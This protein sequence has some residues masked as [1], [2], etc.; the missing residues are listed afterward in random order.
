MRA[1]LG[2]LAPRIR[3]RLPMVSSL[4]LWAGAG[5]VLAQESVTVQA[6]WSAE[7][8]QSSR[9]ELELMLSRTLQTPV[10]R[11]ALLV[12]TLDVSAFVD[13]KGQRARYRPAAAR[14][15]AGESEVIAYVVTAAGDWQ[16]I[17]RF[18]L[19]VRNRV[20]VDRSGVVPVVDL[21]STGQLDQRVADGEPPPARKTYQDLTL[22]MGFEGQVARQGWQIT[23]QANALGVTEKA[24]RLRWSEMQ[25]D[26]PAVDLSDYRIRVAEGRSHLTLGT[27]TAGNHRYLLNNF[28]SRGIATALEAGSFAILDAAV[29]NGTNVVGWSNPFGLMRP[30]HQILSATLSLELLP[31]RPG[32]IHVGISGL[33]GSVLPLTSINQGSVTDAEKNRAMGVA[34][35]LSDA[36]QRFRFS[37]GFARSRYANPADPLLAGD[38]ILVPVQ[39]TVRSARHAELAVQ[40]LRGWALTQSMQTT[41]GATVRHERVDPLYR[42][43]GS[44]GQ[45]DVENNGLELQAT[46]GALA[47]QATASEARDNL[48]HIAS[49][50]TTRTRNRGVTGTLP[51]GTLLR[52]QNAWYWPALNASWQRVRQFG[53]GLPT[54]GDFSA[55]HVPD[56]LNTTES[57]SLGWNRGSASLGYRWNR[58][59]Q[60]NRQTGRERA[61]FRALVH[62]AT[63]S[64]TPGA[65]FTASLDLSAER[66]KN[67]EFGTTQQLERLG[68]TAQWQLLR[69]TALT[70]SLSQSWGRDAMS[71]QKTR[72]SEHQLELAQ[73]FTIYR[74]L[75]SGTQGR[76]ILRY[77]R[78]R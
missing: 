6:G 73:G 59:F 23:T 69:N 19:R 8:F 68:A 58:S 35:M 60:D 34:V 67:V 76:L 53:E 51:L 56:Q 39:T 31:S 26:A 10:E 41:L 70:G 72:N 45:A 44:F 46:V 40:V 62:N 77:A 12:G 61:D 38:T 64:M 20:G 63:L 36:Q 49:I 5:G 50:L 15:P 22:R 13:V 7:Q 66:Q 9:A 11:L 25:A 71:A 27:V 37:G 48:A 28:G 18:P 74:S 43:I 21:S 3:G 29:L 33:N 30:A 47:L 57:A 75:E 52:A 78:A 54:N 24:Q 14:L 4:L 65:R 42:S 2:T 17:G 55:S 1:Q 32:G 16:E